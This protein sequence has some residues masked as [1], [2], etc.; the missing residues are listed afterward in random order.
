MKLSTFNWQSIATCLSTAALLTACG[1]GGDLVIIP[2]PT[3]TPPVTQWTGPKQFNL[4]QPEKGSNISPV[5]LSSTGGTTDLDGTLR[6][7]Q[8]TVSQVAGSEQLGLSAGQPWREDSNKISRST[9]V[10]NGKKQFSVD[11]PDGKSVSLIGGGTA[12]QAAAVRDFIALCTP[13]KRYYMINDAARA[14]YSGSLA[15][16]NG[17]VLQAKNFTAASCSNP[18]SVMQFDGAGNVTLNQSGTT[19]ETLSASEM[20]LL[21]DGGMLIAADGQGIRSM[22]LFEISDAS[23]TRLMIQEFVVYAAN[24]SKNI[25]RIWY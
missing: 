7:F 12:N 9:Q 2:T 6:Y 25:I 20:R 4:T 23:S 14:V 17:Q 21:A 3:P 10:F 16:L 8:S 19:P 11:Y 15:P 13:G 18:A 5:T 24:P 22:K 1:G